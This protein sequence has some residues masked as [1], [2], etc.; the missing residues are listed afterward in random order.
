MMISQGFVQHRVKSIGAATWIDASSGWDGSSTT[1]EVSMTSASFR[2]TGTPVDP[3]APVSGH[4]Y[5]N[6]QVICQFTVDVNNSVVVFI[7]A[8]FNLDESDVTVTGGGSPEELNVGFLTNANNLGYSVS[9][10]EELPSAGA[11]PR[12]FGVSSKAVTGFVISAWDLATPTQYDFSAATAIRLMVT[13][14]G[15]L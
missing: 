7:G 6:N 3:V 1:D 5:G 14:T 9:I 4:L 8:H 12:T 10:M 2:A 13:V 15:E 11:T